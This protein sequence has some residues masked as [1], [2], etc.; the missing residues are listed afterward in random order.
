MARLASRLQ[1]G[2][3]LSNWSMRHLQTFIA[4]LGRL[5]AAPLATLMTAG[6]IGVALSM[7][8]GLYVILGGVNALADGWEISAGIT[9]FLKKDLEE[10]RAAEL[11]A[12]LRAR[13]EVNTVTFIPARDALL[14]FRQYSGL[15]DALDILEENPLPHVIVIEPLVT[16]GNSR[17]VDKLL[18]E[19]RQLPEVESAQMDLVWLERFRAITQIANRAVLVLVALFGLAVI[20][21]TGNTIRLEIRNRQTEIE[22]VKMVGGTDAFIRRPFLYNGL[23][24]GLMGGVIAWALV[25]MALHVL[26][27]SVTELAALY[28]SSLTLPS[29][30]LSD[31]LLL[32]GGS[33]FLGLAGSWLVVGRYIRRIE[34]V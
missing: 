14:E 18:S 31:V 13:P 17:E 4:S 26:S 25:A 28:D 30:T 6:V 32:L 1:S 12:S 22:I 11:T 16:P 33:T 24:Y 8:A 7:P 21:I 23:I 20:L 9:L 27:G 15:H 5:S 19:L 10:R 2:G 34:P 3:G 29:I